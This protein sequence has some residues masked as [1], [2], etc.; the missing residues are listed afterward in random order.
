TELLKAG[1][2]EMRRTI[3]EKEPERPSTRLT[4]ELARASAGRPPRP[5]REERGEG[6]GGG[7][8]DEPHAASPGASSPRPSPPLH[9]GEGAV[10]KGRGFSSHRLVQLKELISLLRGDLDWIVMKCLEK[11]RARRY[12]TANGLA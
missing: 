8:G 3:G 6:G 2:D 11:D 7:A 1:L 12:E 5:A 4:Q 10:S 9:G